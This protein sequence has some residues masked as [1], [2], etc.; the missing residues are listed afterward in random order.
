LYSALVEG[1]ARDKE[2]HLIDEDND[3]G[4]KAVLAQPKDCRN[5][6]CAPERKR[7]S[8]RQGGQKDAQTNVIDRIVNALDHVLLGVHANVRSHDNEG[9]VQAD[10]TGRTSAKER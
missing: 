10:S 9:I 8:G 4:G 5:R 6:R 1:D 2:R 7:D 3:N